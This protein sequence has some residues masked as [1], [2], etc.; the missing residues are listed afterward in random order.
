MTD[1][2]SGEAVAV[3]STQRVLIEKREGPRA[4]F[5]KKKQSSFALSNGK[6][7]RVLLRSDMPDLTLLGDLFT[8]QECNELIAFAQPDV[9]PSQ[10]LDKSNT[11]VV[12][13]MTRMSDDMSIPRR[14]SDLIASLEKRIANIVNWPEDRATGFQIVRHKHRHDFTP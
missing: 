12:R 10:I 5:V 1:K 7:C 3:S 2:S 6:S 14:A 4:P 13:E 9:R 8:E 11:Y